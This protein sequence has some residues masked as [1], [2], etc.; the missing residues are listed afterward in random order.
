MK[1]FVV[2]GM[3][4]SGKNIARSYA[5][6][7]GIPYFATGDVVR[8]EVLRRGLEPEPGKHRCGVNRNAR[9]RWNGGDSEGLAGRHRDR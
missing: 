4:A 2:V 3:P 8:A 9:Q 7:N 6:S 5:E 1:M